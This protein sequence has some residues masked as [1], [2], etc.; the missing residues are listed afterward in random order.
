MKRKR[1]TKTDRRRQSH[2]ANATTYFRSTSDGMRRY[3]RGRRPDAF[4][5][6]RRIFRTVEALI[7][8][9]NESSEGER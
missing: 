9:L 7:A 8:A 2:R 1:M 4:L 6:R 5:R 3:Y